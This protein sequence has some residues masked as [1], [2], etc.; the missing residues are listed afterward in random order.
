MRTFFIAG[1]D[2]GVG[3]TVVAGALAAALKTKG[4]KVGVMK[5]VACGSPEDAHFLKVCAGSTDPLDLI[6]PIY[7]KSALSPNVAAVVE[8]KKIDVRK[9]AATAQKLKQK[10]YDY[11]VVEGCGGLLVPVTNPS[12]SSGRRFFVVDIIKM[13]KAET[14][15]VSRSGLGAINHSLLSLEALKNRRIKPLGIIFNRLSGGPMSVP[16]KTNPGVIAEISHTRS[17][18]MF[19]YMKMDCATDCLGKAFLKHIDLSKL[20]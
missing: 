7:L 9:I 12:T 19:P 8:K 6:M 17:L 3:K 5:P 13:L 4:Y 11:L 15:L 2:T 18:G 20:V 10:K 1:T 16:E 14:I